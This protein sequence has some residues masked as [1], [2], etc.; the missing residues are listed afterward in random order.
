MLI[1]LRLAETACFILAAWLGLRLL[2]RFR[3]G[4]AVGLADRHGI[5]ALLLVLAGLLLGWLRQIIA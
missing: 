5:A 2:A 3:R 4:V 1:A